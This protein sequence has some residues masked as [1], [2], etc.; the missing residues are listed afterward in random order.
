MRLSSRAEAR[1]VPNGFSTITRTQLPLHV[2]FKLAGGFFE[3]APEFL[4]TFF[5][6]RESDN[7]HSGRQVAIGREVVERRDEFSMG[8]IARSAEDHNGA[9]LRHG[10]R[11][12]SFPER[13]W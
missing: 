2:S 8:E 7:G 13:V 9:W 6:A 4:V 12:N 11:G 5:T 10:A 3:I 1:S